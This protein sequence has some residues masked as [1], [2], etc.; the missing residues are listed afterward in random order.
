MKAEATARPA[1]VVD[2]RVI[3]AQRAEGSGLG[4]PLTL[5]ETIEHGFPQRG[6]PDEVND[7]RADNSR[8][9]F[10]GM[11]KNLR[12][13]RVAR[14]LELP[15]FWSQLW[16]VKISPDGARL[17]LGLASMRV[18]TTVGVNA[19]VDAFVGTDLLSDFNFHGIGTGST[20]EATGDT[21]LVTELTTEYQT[22]NTRATG[23]QA[24]GASANIFQT[25]GTNTVDAAVG[26][27]EHGVLNQAATGG[28]ILLD[29][30]VFA[31][32]NLG[33]SDSLE[34]TYELT[35]AAGG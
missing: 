5:L 14:R 35:V 32:V 29:R 23:T 15:H 19:I 25:V 26:I 22:D 27:Q 28:G 1:G 31:V 24:E 18:V 7:W 2:L 34:S 13:R 17:P 4:R 9:T 12:A 16:L 8:H 20:A 3:R 30:S 21:A 10:R 6:L 11:R 33:I